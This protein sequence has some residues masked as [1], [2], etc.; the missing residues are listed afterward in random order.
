MSF[1]NQDIDNPSVLITGGSGFLG[2][3]IV[4]ELLDPGSPFT[5]GEI[6]ILD[7]KE[8]QGR[9]DN[10]IKFIRGNICN[11]EEVLKATRGTDLVIHSAAV[12]DW[13][14]KKEEDV[15]RVNFEGTRNVVNACIENNVPNLVYTSSLDTVISGKPL[16]N[17]D[18]TQS[19][20]EKHP[21]M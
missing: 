18:E 15:Y 8:Y 21:N 14:T 6:R 5:A 4:E 12:V 7:K 20:P 3:A 11:Y 1:T 17:I 19:Y 2:Q 16:V 9:P 10:R 13:G